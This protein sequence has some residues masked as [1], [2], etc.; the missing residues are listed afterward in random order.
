MVVSSGVAAVAS[1]VSIVRGA[2]S[3][4]LVCFSFLDVSFIPGL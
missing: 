2:F 1:S 4:L 3:E